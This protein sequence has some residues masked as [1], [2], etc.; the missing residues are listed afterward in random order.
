MRMQQQQMQMQMQKIQQI[1]QMQGFVSPA[2]SAIKPAAVIM[3]PP[4][5]AT[6]HSLCPGCFGDKH[7]DGKRAGETI[8][9]A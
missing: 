5:K 6:A 9:E 7:D 1:P 4:T 8:N 2:P 3:S